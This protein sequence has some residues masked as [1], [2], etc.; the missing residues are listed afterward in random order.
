MRSSSTPSHQRVGWGARRK[1]LE[2]LLFLPFH[3][4][5]AIGVYGGK[6]M[7]RISRCMKKIRSCRRERE[8]MKVLVRLLEWFLFKTALK[9]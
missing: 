1:L 3:G 5:P 9:Y 7:D 6:L 4:F 2:S 8:L